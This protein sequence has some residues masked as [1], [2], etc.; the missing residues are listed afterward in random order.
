MS[1]AAR[2]KRKGTRG[3]ARGEAGR[4][5]YFLAKHRGQYRKGAWGPGVGKGARRRHAPP[6][7][8]PVCPPCSS[9]RKDESTAEM[10]DYCR[11]WE[12]TDAGR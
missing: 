5:H 4:E 3:A 6:G 9:P 11:K 1:A 7:C 8:A 2:L 12:F 10:W